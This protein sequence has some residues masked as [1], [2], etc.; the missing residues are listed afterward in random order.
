LEKSCDP[1]SMTQFTTAV[2]KY[3]NAVIHPA[4][5]PV[6]GSAGQQQTTNSSQSTSTDCS[7][8][9][10]SQ[11]NISVEYGMLSFSNPYA[12]K[13][14]L[15]ISGQ[16]NCQATWV[17]IP[18][19]TSVSMGSRESKSIFMGGLFPSALA[20]CKSFMTMSGMA[21]DGSGGLTLCANKACLSA[22]SFVGRVV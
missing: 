20:S 11:I 15:Q 4:K 22:F 5:K 12:C 8:L 13:I 9:T 19:S 10:G 7:R 6:S 16:I 2:P 3:S 21:F 17:P 1:Q 14:S 18:V